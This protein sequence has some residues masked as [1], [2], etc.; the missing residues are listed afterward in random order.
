[1][2]PITGIAEPLLTSRQY[3]ELL[4]GQFIPSV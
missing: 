2:D 1:M 4:H 3:H